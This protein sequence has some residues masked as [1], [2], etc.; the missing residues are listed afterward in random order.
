LLA[1]T[2]LNCLARNSQHLLF[3]FQRP[4]LRQRLVFRAARNPVYTHGFF[5]RQHFFSKKNIFTLTT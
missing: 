1:F 5:L 4:N 2:N 3:G